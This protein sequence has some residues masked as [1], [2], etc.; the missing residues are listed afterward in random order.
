MQDITV[1]ELKDRMDKQEDL[2]IVDVREPWEYQEFNI[3]AKLMPLGSFQTAVN[4]LSDWKDKEVILH[5][6]SGGR[7]GAAKN[8]LMAQGFTNV[9]NLLGG[10]MAWQ[11][12]SNT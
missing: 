3:G 7:S 4:E 10:M 1:Q 11:A 12:M 5:C 9:R 2:F 6:K 8:F